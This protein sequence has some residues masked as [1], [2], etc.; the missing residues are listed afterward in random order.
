MNIVEARIHSLSAIV[1]ER[2]RQ[3][4]LKAQGKFAHTCADPIPLEKAFS[5]LVEE[6]GEVGKALNENNPA[7]VVVELTQVAAVA[8]AWLEGLRL[9]HTPADA[10]ERLPGE[11]SGV[12]N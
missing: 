6:V 11:A 9:H 4:V 7:D 5:I 2:E 1:N 12:M 10:A 8:L 3:D